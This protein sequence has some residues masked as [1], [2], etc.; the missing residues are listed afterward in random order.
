MKEPWEEGRQPDAINDVGSEFY[1]LHRQ[2]HELK[3][4]VSTGYAIKGLGK[5]LVIRVRRGDIRA[6]IITNGEGSVI[7]DVQTELDLAFE[8]EKIRMAYAVKE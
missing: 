8:M 1:I 2:T 6:Y 5:F 3:H 4:N 7:S